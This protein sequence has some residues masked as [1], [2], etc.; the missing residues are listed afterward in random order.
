MSVPAIYEDGV[1]KPL[2]RVDLAE[3]AS[4]ELEIVRKPEA[5][6]AATVWDR[7]GKGLL[8]QPSEDFDKLGTEWDE[9]V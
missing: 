6:P 5:A 7:F 9:Y 3:H 4:V 1:F 2:V 8:G